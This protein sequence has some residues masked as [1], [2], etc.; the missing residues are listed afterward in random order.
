MP[1]NSTTEL[2][3]QILRNWSPQSRAASLGQRWLQ[4][5]PSISDM[6]DVHLALD[7][8]LSSSGVLNLKI[9][10]YADGK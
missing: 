6:E 4:M 5:L 1:T 3:I 2:T 7:E 9:L 10:G 8:M